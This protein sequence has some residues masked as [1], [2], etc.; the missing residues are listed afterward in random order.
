MPRAS[1]QW[2]ASTLL[3]NV[4]FG[5]RD[6]SHYSAIYR[7]ITG[8]I[9]VTPGT[10]RIKLSSNMVSQDLN[11]HLTIFKMDNQHGPTG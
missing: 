5:S 11:V 4:P 8:T 2:A 9:Q 3:L 7:V 1:P 10:K 6:T